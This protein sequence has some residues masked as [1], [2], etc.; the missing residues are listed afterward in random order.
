M[1][2]RPK[3]VSHKSKPLN[4]Q[5]NINYSYL[6]FCTLPKISEFIKKS[7]FLESTLH[8]YNIKVSPGPTL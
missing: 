2:S 7:M 1:G 4:V 5:H 8:V 6:R 3:A